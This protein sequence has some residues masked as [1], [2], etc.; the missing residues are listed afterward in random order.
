MHNFAVRPIDP[1]R[2]G[3]ILIIAMTVSFTMAM[4]VLVMCRTMAVEAMASANEAALIQ[5]DAVE[6]GA[7]QYAIGLLSTNQAAVMG[8]TDDYF[9]AIQVGDGYFWILRP[10]YEDAWLPLYGFVDECSKLD[11][12]YATV[13]QLY[14]LPGMTDEAAPAIVDW[15]SAGAAQ[16]GGAKDDYYLSL[17]DPYYCKQSPYETV[18]E[19]M[20]VRGVTREMLYGDGTA[21]PL[22]Q[23]S[24]LGTTNRPL[25]S[26]P[27]LSRGLFD[28][29]TVHAYSPRTGGGG[30]NQ[31]NRGRVN[32]NTAPREVL[33]TLI[34]FGIQENDVDNL[35]S[36]RS[37][38]VDPSATDTSWVRQ[39]VGN[40]GDRFNDRICGQSQ[41]YS[42]DILAVS[43]N[44]RAFR[45]VRIVIDSTQTPPAI[46]YRRD[47]TD[48]GWPMD[49]E[50]LTSLRN[51][52]WAGQTGSSMMGGALR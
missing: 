23:Q 9:A 41:R 26:D 14:M 1:R 11:L 15:R 7:E 43:G 51:G 38:N 40:R 2:R 16:P 27:T 49:Q 42:A 45:R 17:P 21:P 22:G 8:L 31:P 4:V 30:G 19:V 46:I 39:V 25:F 33:M 47:M 12:N 50:I 24:M 52:T 32:V 37:A 5:A 29:F 36:Y 6:R 10:N 48:R 13:D 28:L 44:G 18:E 35:I 34:P 20:L 3:A